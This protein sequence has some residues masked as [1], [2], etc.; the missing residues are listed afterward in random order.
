MNKFFAMVSDAFDL[1]Q[2]IV[3]VGLTG[4]LL[5]GGL[6]FAVLMALIVAGIPLP[7]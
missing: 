5:V 4:V 1:L 2:L 3:V 7:M 6:W